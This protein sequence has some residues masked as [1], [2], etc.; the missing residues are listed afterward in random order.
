[1]TKS[2]QFAV[3]ATISLRAVATPA[4][5]SDKPPAGAGGRGEG[6]G[7]KGDEEEV[8]V[9]AALAPRHVLALPAYTPLPVW[10]VS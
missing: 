2:D 3:A 4:D 6:T 10:L 9:P 8:L 7:E 5:V 1:M